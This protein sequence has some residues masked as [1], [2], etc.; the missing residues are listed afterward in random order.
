MFAIYLFLADGSMT[1]IWSAMEF[2]AVL[3]FLEAVA[4]A[5]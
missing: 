1:A 4:I 2:G 3:L 5:A